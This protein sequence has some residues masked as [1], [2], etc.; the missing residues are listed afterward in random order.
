MHVRTTVQQ[1]WWSRL[2]PLG[3]PE[4]RARLL[5]V[6]H[7]GG[8]PNRYL[9]LLGDLPDDVEILGLTLP[10]RERRA[11]EPPG[12][13]LGEV[14]DSLGEIGRTGPPA[15]VLGHSL[16]A[17]LGLH[18]AHALGEHC[19]GLIASGQEPRDAVTWL[20]EHSG[21]EDLLQLLELG[22]D[23]PSVILDVPEWRTSLL[24]NLRA[25]LRLGR[26][27]AERSRGIRID[28][29]ITALCG[30]EDRLVDEDALPGWGAHSAAECEVRVFPGGHFALFDP[31]NQR[32]Y[33]EAIER[34][35]AAIAEIAG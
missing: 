33:I 10:G 3:E 27:S 24:G 2:R 34:R 22:G 30:R 17:T 8:G 23:M 6:P 1:R 21:D 11:T 20:S 28:A 4:P 5:V 18:I 32:Q 29:P 15:L 25:D 19:V 12:A 14:L 13:T 16:G 26:E 9:R 35:F 7:S 31:V